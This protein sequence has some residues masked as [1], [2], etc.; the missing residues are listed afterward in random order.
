MINTFLGNTGQSR[1]LDGCKIALTSY[2]GNTAFEEWHAHENSGI[3]FLLNGAHEEDLLG[4]KY[5]RAPGDLKF[6]PAGELH[7][8]NNYA[9]GTRKINIDFD[10]S[11]IRSMAVTEGQL[12][13]LIPQNIHT[14]FVLIKLYRELSD[15]AAHADTSVELLLHTLVNPVS[16]STLKTGKAAPEWAARLREMHDEWDKPFHLNDLSARLGVHPVTISRCFPLYFSSTLGVYMNQIKVDKALALIKNSELSLT[17]IA[18]SCG[19]ADQAHFTR[20]FRAVT[21]YLPKTFRKL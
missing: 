5:K 14:K 19:F 18:Y 12:I 13:D 7:R 11:F 10:E 15:N 2:T 1:L 16:V 17:A 6:I 3:S 4:K 21:G 20:T 9:A 8:C